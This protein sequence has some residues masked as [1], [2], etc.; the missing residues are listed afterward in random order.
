MCGSESE[1]ESEIES[2]TDSMS[3]VCEKTRVS[4]DCG[5]SK[6]SC[7][8]EETL[9]RVCEQTL[10]DLS[11][12]ASQL[13]S[14]AG[15]IMVRFVRYAWPAGSY[16]VDPVLTRLLPRRTQLAGSYRVNPVLTWL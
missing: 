12:S 5:Q 2:E 13:G 14:I 10:V 1:S 11:V 7:V 9:G 4:F 8:C 15:K 3:I 6:V 16:R